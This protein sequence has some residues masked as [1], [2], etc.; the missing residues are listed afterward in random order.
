MFQ[1]AMLYVRMRGPHRH[2]DMPLLSRLPFLSCLF[3][4]P[5]C[6]ACR[7]FL[8]AF[9]YLLFI[10]YSAKCLSSIRPIPVK[11]PPCVRSVES[12]A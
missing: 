7:I 11:Y 8:S 5:F 9:I 6:Y 3:L 10:S 1:V 2:S 4:L 12:Q